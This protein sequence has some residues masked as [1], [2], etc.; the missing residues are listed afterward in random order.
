MKRV[1]MDICNFIN[2]SDIELHYLKTDEEAKISRFFLVYI[3]AE[4]NVYYIK[5][6]HNNNL[7]IIKYTDRYYI[8]YNN[9]ISSEDIA[10][11]TLDIEKD[12]II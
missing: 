11:L 4:K 7:C 9:K 1:K 8:K 12:V 2:A 5:I 3:I 6:I 10:S